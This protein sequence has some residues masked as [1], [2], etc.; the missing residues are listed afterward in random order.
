MKEK[1]LDDK[2]ARVALRAPDVFNTVFIENELLMVGRPGGS[3]LG[4]YE[5]SHVGGLIRM[6][7]VQNLV[8]TDTLNDP[9]FVPDEDILIQAALN[10]LERRLKDEIRLAVTGLIY[11]GKSTN[12][13]GWTTHL[14][15]KD[16]DE[17]PWTSVDPKSSRTG[18]IPESKFTEK[19]ADG[20]YKDTDE[21]L[22]MLSGHAD[23]GR[24][25]IAALDLIRRT[26]VESSS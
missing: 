22:H 11:L 23:M 17:K 16:L 8:D 5:D 4:K 9:D 14:F 1:F 15:A 3:K 25:A 18:W 6:K 19:N 24:I 7:D 21:S 20:F 2:V 26:K 10:A 13:E 12:P